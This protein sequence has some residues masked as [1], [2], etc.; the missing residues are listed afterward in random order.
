MR[1]LL[2]VVRENPHCAVFINDINQLDCESEVAMKNLIAI[3]SIMD[4]NGSDMVNLEDTI[5]VLSTEENI[6][7]W[8]YS[9]R[10]SV[11]PSKQQ[12]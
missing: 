7:S 4:G 8:H 9:F 10:H 5:L 11:E 6:L 2:Q 3:G 12:G 1:R